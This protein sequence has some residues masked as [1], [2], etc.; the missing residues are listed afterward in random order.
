MNDYDL[1]LCIL[2][3]T[4]S[5]L[6]N[7]GYSGEVS[8]L[9]HRMASIT[10]IKLVFSV[11]YC[12][13]G[14]ETGLAFSEVF[15]NGNSPKLSSKISNMKHDNDSSQ[16]LASALYHGCGMTDGQ[17]F[18]MIKC[19]SKQIGAIKIKLFGKSLKLPGW[20]YLLDCSG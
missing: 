12:I 2:F 17:N 11:R 13:P 14:W 10:Q 18:L 1:Y 19:W 5:P 7:C 9:Y 3:Y 6:G 16:V 4:S 8:S 15:Y 20:K